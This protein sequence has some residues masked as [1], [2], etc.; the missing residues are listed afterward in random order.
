[1]YSVL[2]VATAESTTNAANTS[3]PTIQIPR[4]GRRA[5]SCGSWVG[6]RAVMY[7]SP[8]R[9]TSAATTTASTAATMT[10]VSACSPVD[11]APEVVVVGIGVIPN[12]EWLAGSGLLIE[13]GEVVAAQ[14]DDQGSALTIGV[15]IAEAWLAQTVGQQR[16][17]LIEVAAH[18]L[19]A[20][21]ES[22]ELSLE[23]G[24]GIAI[25]DVALAMLRIPIRPGRNIAALIEVAARNQLLKQQGK[26]SAR[27]FQDRI[28][29]AAELHALI[30]RRQKAAAPQAVVKRL[31]FAPTR[32]KRRHDD[33]SRQ[34]AVQATETIAEPRADAG[35][36]GELRARLAKRDRWIVIDRFRVHRTDDAQLVG[37]P[38][39]VRQQLADPRAALSMLRKTKRR[40]R[41]G[42]RGLL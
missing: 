19:A 4:N 29:R 42:Q 6:G 10:G 36:S 17:A 33:I 16:Q 2:H 31:V 8:N 24:D 5:R 1:M 27:D 15:G 23:E 37:D 40:G 21:T 18:E 22:V 3:P 14:L 20:Q 39:G 26:H 38:R 12:T 32:A 35:P 34:I 7:R 9:R 41:D 30:H 28:T 25:L 13:D 11:W